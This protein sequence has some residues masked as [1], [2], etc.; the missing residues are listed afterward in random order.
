MM[1]EPIHAV[2]LILVASAVTAAIR[3][4]PFVLFRHGTPKPIQYL[5]QVLP[6]AVMAMLV[7]YCLKDVSL[8]SGTHGIP[9]LLAL[10]TVVLL[11]KWKHNTLLSIVSGTAVYM[12]LI[13][14]L[15]LI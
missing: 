1:S 4:L 3:F 15:A 11:H 5:A 13:R 8:V 12:I 2:C 9:E 10:L 14:V 6:Y 7:V